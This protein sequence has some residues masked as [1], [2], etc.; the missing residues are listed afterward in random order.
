MT[1]SLIQNQIETYLEQLDKELRGVAPE[2]KAEII[3]E[4]RAHIMDSIA[5]APDAGGALERVL[6]MLGTPKELA[7]RYTTESLLTRASHSFSPLVLIRTSWQWAMMGIKGMLAFLLAI[8]GYGM[9]LA[10]TVSLLM[11]PFMLTAVGLWLG[12]H[13]LEI[14]TTNDPHSRELLG[15]WFIPVIAAAAFLIAVGT[16]Q[17]L[18]RL[19]RKRALKPAY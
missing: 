10:L 1:T 13:N 14:G 19:F 3:R 7:Q 17:G 6:R 5:D 9:A 16:T 15:S 8:F 4:I 12:P 11:K 18:R 2:E